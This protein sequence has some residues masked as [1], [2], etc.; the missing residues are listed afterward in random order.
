MELRKR[1]TIKFLTFLSILA[2][3]LL[4]AFALIIY[5]SQSHTSN[6][7][8]EPSELLNALSMETVL[9][10]NTVS[11]PSDILQ[12]VSKNKGWL[13]ILD[14]TGNVIF[15][16]D[17]PDDIQSSY[18]PGELLVY[19]KSPGTFGYQIYTWYREIGI[20]KITWVYAIPY[21]EQDAHK[22]INDPH[23]WIIIAGLSLVVTLV[24]AV[25]FGWRMG[26]PILYVL[27]WI[28]NLANRIY[29]EPANRK[30][31]NYSRNSTNKWMQ[32]PFRTYREIMHSMESLSNSL[33]ENEEKKRQLE[34]AKE[35]WIAGISHDMKTPLSSV[36]G[37]ADLLSSGRYEFSQEQICE[38]SGIIGEKAAYMEELIEDL[39]LTYSLSNNALPF[40]FELHNIVELARRSVIDFINSGLIQGAQVHFENSED[41][42]I[43]CYI[44]TKRFKRAVDNILSNAAVHNESGTQISVSINTI[45]NT[46]TFPLAEIIIKD[47][48]KGMDE[49]T[50]QHLF[51]RYF[52]GA[53]I[54]DR[55]ENSSGLGMAIAKQLIEAHNGSILVDSKL[56]IGTKF[57]IRLPKN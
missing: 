24:I 8:L 51:E 12:S 3:Y 47:N 54:N 10:E 30:K 43:F 34:N 40:H 53:N 27:D 36:R 49:Q 7:S 48:G 19:K 17:T 2:A 55:S 46:G 9:N 6:N 18:A 1:I 45:R 39:N 41:D 14:G 38:Y 50:Q 42:E 11:I 20:Q 56:G 31:P 25:I 4:V 5:F 29:R 16:Y 28:E 44:D 13:Q 21:N 37:Y 33:R 52:R 32:G 26:M 57:I 23:T 22:L 35:E 15:N